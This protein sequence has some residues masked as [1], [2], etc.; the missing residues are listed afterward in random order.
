MKEF[1]SIAKR[2][3]FDREGFCYGFFRGAVGSALLISL[4]MMFTACFG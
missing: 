1:V 3:M 4:L 2:T